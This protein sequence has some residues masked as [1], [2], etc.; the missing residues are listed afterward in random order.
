MYLLTGAGMAGEDTMAV[1]EAMSGM[2]A[3]PP[4]LSSSSFTALFGMWSTMM[5]AMMLPNAAP[6]I[7]LYERVHG[8]AAATQRNG[9]LAPV[10]L[11]VL[12]YLLCWVA[13]SL[14]MSVLQAVLTSAG[15]FPALHFSSATW[16]PGVLLTAAGLYQLSPFKNLCL[17]H[18]RSPA[19]F[20]ARNWRPGPVGALRLGLLHGAFCVGCCW[21]VM[22][23]LFVGGVMNMP[24]VI[25]LAAFVLTEKLF[26]YGQTVRRISGALLITVGLAS[27]LLIGR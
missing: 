12:G 15:L 1:H 24:W 6:A 20:F 19:L 23:L 7:L 8:H 22:L 17:T 4:S 25:L 21:A 2:P 18:C 16:V 5:V 9:T 26:F 14:V 11:F 27:L 3:E 10:S 13:F